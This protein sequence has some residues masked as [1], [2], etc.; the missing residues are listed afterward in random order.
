MGID[1]IEKNPDQEKIK[2]KIQSLIASGN[3]VVINIHWGK[4]YQATH[5]TRQEQFAHELIDAGVR[6]VIGHHPHVVQDQEIYK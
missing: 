1:L 5:D 6:L 2:E 3:I 4:E